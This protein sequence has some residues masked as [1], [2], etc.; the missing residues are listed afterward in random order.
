MARPSHVPTKATRKVVQS[1][2]GF[3]FTH[4]EIG[5][6]VGLT[7]KPLRSHYR[8]ELDRG[9]IVAN[10]EVAA[11]LF[12]ATRV[13]VPAAIFWLKARAGWREKLAID[14]SSDDGSMTPRGL[15]DFYASIAPASK[16]PDA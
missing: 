12:K 4:A 10:A 16:D 5:E 1:L 14:L 9:V 2:A 15:G 8:K 7:E 3:G 6:H 11:R 13:S